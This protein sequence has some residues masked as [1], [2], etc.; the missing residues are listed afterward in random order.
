[1][2]AVSSIHRE[3]RADSKEPAS[4]QSCSAL[5][6]AGRQPSHAAAARVR[7]HQ[8]ASQQGNV[9]AMLAIGDA[10]YYGKGL[11]RDWGQAFKVYSSAA[12]HRSSQVGLSI[13]HRDMQTWASP[14]LWQSDLRVVR[15][16]RT[17]HCWTTF[18]SPGFPKRSNL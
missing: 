18:L 8:R 7:A 4:W 3:I 1:M 14:G 6:C 2:H 5:V 15:Q 9:K 17:L 13:K 12:H 10:Y 11:A 16:R